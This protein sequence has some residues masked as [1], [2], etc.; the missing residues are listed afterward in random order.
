MSDQ[1]MRTA[2]F[3]AT[4]S[5]Y[6]TLPSDLPVLLTV[7]TA[8]RIGGFSEKFIRDMLTRGKVP[9]VK[10][11]GAWRINRDCYLQLLGLV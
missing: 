2:E 3:T 9:G 1:C 10:V 7:R 6:T 4:G 11:G 8:A 5:T